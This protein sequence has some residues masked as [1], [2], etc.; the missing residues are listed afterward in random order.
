MRPLLTGSLCVGRHATDTDPGRSEHDAP[1]GSDP[2][3]RGENLLT[4][5]KTAAA[6]AYD[7]KTVPVSAPGQLRVSPVSVMGQSSAVSGEA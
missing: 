6:W 1:G 2:S 5:V 7:L 3:D 4:G